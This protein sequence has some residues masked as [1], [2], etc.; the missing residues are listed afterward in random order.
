MRKI[1]KDS[2]TDAIF[3]KGIMTKVVISFGTHAEQEQDKDDYA[4]QFEFAPMIHNGSS[5]MQDYSNSNAE[6]LNAMNENG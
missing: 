2:Y 4:Y 1:L 3:L 5:R 6:K